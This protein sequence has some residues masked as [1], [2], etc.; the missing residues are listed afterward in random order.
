MSRL[1]MWWRRLWAGRAVNG[2]DPDHAPLR[3]AEEPARGGESA[4]ETGS[5][6]EG[7]GWDQVADAA[8][9]AMSGTTDSGEAHRARLATAEGVPR[10]DR[11]TE[12]GE[13]PGSDLHGGDVLRADRL[14]YAHP[15][16]NDDEAE[17]IIGFDLGTSTSKIIVHA[18][19]LEARFLAER[20]TGGAHEGPAWLWPSALSVDDKGTCALGG[21]TSNSVLRGIKLDLM[22]VAAGGEDVAADCNVAG[23]AVTAYLAIVLRAARSQIL[24][25]HASVFRHYATVR[26]SLNMGIPSGLTGESKDEDLRIERLFERAVTGGWQLS[27]R[28][29]PIRLEDAEVAFQRCDGVGTDG[30]RDPANLEIAVFPEVV[31]GVV[32][33]DRSDSRRDGLHLAVDVG[34]ATVDVCLFNLP[35]ETDAPWPLLEARVERLGV[36]ELHRRRVAAVADINPEAAE[37]LRRSYDPLNG[38]AVVPRIP[39]GAP[40]FSEMDA[41]DRKMRR[42]VGNLIGRFVQDG[43]TRRNP[44]AAAYRSDG[45]IPTL[46]M[47]GGSGTEFYRRALRESGDRFAELLGQHHRGLEILDVPV[48]HDVDR[49]SDGMGHRLAVAVGVS[50]RGLNLPDHERPSEVADVVNPDTERRIG[51][52]IAAC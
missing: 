9:S 18:P 45:G 12:L 27:L 21:A 8:I 35:T 28:D 15:S 32:G 14:W 42:D 48:P 22:E 16:G 31:A 34:A 33:Y 30:G 49:D 38:I 37:R 50:E 10:D 1:S 11:D 2:G 52:S 4:S 36:A 17:L 25:K 6:E 3:P 29:E 39:G 7:G 13:G 44:N 41:A 40:G 43:K 51:P 23:A 19:S 5:V 46:V 47:G 24:V 26:W 20:E